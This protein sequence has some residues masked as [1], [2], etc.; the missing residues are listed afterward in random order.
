MAYSKAINKQE[1]RTGSLFQKAFKNK[2]I[3]KAEYYSTIIAYIHFNPVKAGLC[4]SPEN[5]KFSSYNTIL[6]EKNSLINR[7]EVLDWFN[8]KTGF[9]DFHSSYTEFQEE[10]ANAL[11]FF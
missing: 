6:S 10:R 9:I 5:W 2:E 11:L 7:E 1:N 3:T 4:S 8:G